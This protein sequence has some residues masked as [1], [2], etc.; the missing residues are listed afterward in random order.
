MLAL[1]G[2]VATAKDGQGWGPVVLGENDEGGKIMDVKNRLLSEIVPYEKTRR[3]TTSG[4]SRT[5]RRASSSMALFSR[6]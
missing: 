6:L 4:R 5:L 3:S 1:R 2:R